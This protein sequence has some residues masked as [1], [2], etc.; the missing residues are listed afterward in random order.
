MMSIN[1]LLPNVLLWDSTACSDYSGMPSHG[2]R[3]IA[4]VQLSHHFPSV[5]LCSLLHTIFT[6]M[7]QEL[8]KILDLELLAF[9]H[10]HDCH[11]T[12]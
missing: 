9:G 10:C 5:E 12:N 6:N 7:R 4:Q 3:V 2:S 8:M 1:K 11:V